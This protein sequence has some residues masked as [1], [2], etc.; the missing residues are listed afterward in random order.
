MLITVLFLIGELLISSTTH[1]FDGGSPRRVI[2]QFAAFA[3]GMAAM[4]LVR[5]VDYMDFKKFYKLFYAVGIISLLLVYVPGLGSV[6]GGARGWIKLGKI[7]VQPIE[8]AKLTFIISYAVYLDENAGKLNT[9]DQIAKALVMPIPILVLLVLQPDLGGA[10]VFMCIT[11]GMLFFA[12]INLRIVTNALIISVLLFP[13]IYSYGLN[14]LMPYQADRIRDFFSFENGSGSD[15]ALK[16]AI[17][18]VSGGLTGKGPFKGDQ[19]RFGF[20]PVSESDFIFAVAG[21]EYG[22]IGMGII[23]ALYGLF[24]TKLLKIAFSSR[25]MYGSLIVMGITSLF[26]YQFIQNVGMTIGLMPVT[27]LTLPFMSYGGSSMI[28]SMAEIFIVQCVAI[29]RRY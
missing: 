14:L 5:Y 21:E 20:L 27:G 24:L 17:A 8:I 25:D 28:M 11:F 22:I 2:I 7:N 15:H 12:G 6:Q 18:I 29:R 3:A 16:S 13:L 1:V 19:H 10:I 23:I 26:I 4:P 9:I